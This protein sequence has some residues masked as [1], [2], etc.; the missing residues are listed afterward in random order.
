MNNL[1]VLLWNRDAEAAR[2]WFEKAAR[3]GNTDAI[4]T[5]RR[6]Y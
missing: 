3:A 4:N 1:G 2:D 5:L 6:L